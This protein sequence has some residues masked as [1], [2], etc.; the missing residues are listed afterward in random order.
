MGKEDDRNEIKVRELQA[1]N[2]DEIV[3]RARD[4][5]FE[6]WA[7]KDIS[8]QLE[9]KLFTVQK[10]CTR[11]QWRKQREELEIEAHS[12]AVR[13]RSK[14]VAEIVKSGIWAIKSTIQKYSESGAM[15][16]KDVKI[17]SDV[18]ANL[19]KMTRLAEGKSTEITEE[20]KLKASVTATTVIDAVSGVDPF[21]VRDVTGAD[22][23]ED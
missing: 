2:R 21:L 19:D 14:E 10:W 7:L 17:M 18:L 15:T 13:A 12:D 3:H 22:E 6:G 9:L 1:A 8:E 11:Y 23:D 4:M 5:F 16:M 20:R